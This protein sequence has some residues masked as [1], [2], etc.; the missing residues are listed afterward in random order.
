MTVPPQFVNQSDLLRQPRFSIGDVLIRLTEAL[1]LANPV[2]RPISPAQSTLHVSAAI[3]DLLDCLLHRCL[4][5][6]R[7]LGLV[8][9]SP[10]RLQR[11]RGPA[12]ARG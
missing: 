12:Y 2:S 8:T 4:G 11:E 5:A 7:L 6:M 10:I 9:H 3:A 1:D